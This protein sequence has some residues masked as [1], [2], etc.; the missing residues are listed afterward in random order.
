MLCF[1]IN[2]AVLHL[3]IICYRLIILYVLVDN[4]KEYMNSYN[5][6]NSYEQ[7]KLLINT[8]IKLVFHKELL[9]RIYLVEIMKYILNED[10]L[11]I[12]WIF[13]FS[14][15]NIYYHKN[16]DNIVILS[17]FIKSVILSCYL[18]NTTIIGSVVIHLYFDISG[19]IIQK[20]LFNIFTNKPTITIAKNEK[21]SDINKSILLKNLNPTIELASKEDVEKLLSNKKME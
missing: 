4:K 13:I 15:F 12:S 1:L 5:V 21:A 10:E 17:N 7:L 19:I 3:T 2:T 8:N 11:I 16:S 6:H 18:I 9:F 20:Y 14:L